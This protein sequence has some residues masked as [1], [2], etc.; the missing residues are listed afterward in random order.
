MSQ[1]LDKMYCLQVRA[2][3]LSFSKIGAMAR[4]GEVPGRLADCALP[5]LCA[6]CQSSKATRNPW[7]TKTKSK[8]IQVATLPGECA[9]VDQME[10]RMP[11]F[12]AQH[13]GCL[14]KGRY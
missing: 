12:V 11:G 5:M 4:Q 2:G 9:S 14:T 13:K 6:A 7:R 1:D 10:F 8:G 3:R